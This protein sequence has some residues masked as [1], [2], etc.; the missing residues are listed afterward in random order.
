MYIYKK[1]LKSNKYRLQHEVEAVKRFIG[2]GEAE[3]N[4]A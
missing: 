2:W 3:A 1:L 4:K